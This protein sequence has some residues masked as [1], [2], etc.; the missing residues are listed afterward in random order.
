MDAVK[1]FETSNVFSKLAALETSC[2][3][4]LSLTSHVEVASTAREGEIRDFW[5]MPPKIG[6]TKREGQARLL[7]DL[8]NIELQA[9]ELALRS[10]C[11]FP[12][13][14]KE[15]REELCALAID[16]GRHLK[17]C[18]N[19]LSDLGY[20]WGDW[21]IHMN[22]WDAVSI[23]DTLLDRLVIVHR[24][25]E[26]AGLDAGAG[27]MKRLTSSDAKVVHSIVG[28]IMREEIGHV[29]FGSKWYHQIC[30]EQKLDIEADFRLRIEKVIQRNPKKENLDYDLRK[31]A[32]F[33]DEELRAMEELREKYWK[34]K[35]KPAEF[36]GQK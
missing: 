12:E 14:P 26:G 7:H 29:A 20:K 10:L 30:R 5:R 31:K 24:Y 4:A 33:L 21:P 32:G 1:V 28:T 11:E 25:L 34:L 35:I 8:A 16:E 15:L 36:S 17:L 6:F 2:H 13:A 3:A 18:L 27:V 9:T 22:L 23:K 19:G